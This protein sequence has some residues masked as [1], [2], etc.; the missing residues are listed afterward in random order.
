R[1]IRSACPT[2]WPTGSGRGMTV[3]GGRRAEPGG[4]GP[5]VA[6]DGSARAWGLGYPR[7]TAI[8]G[9]IR[10][11]VRMVLDTDVRAVLPAIR[12]PTLVLHRTEDAYVR[13]DHGR[14][15]ADH[16]PGARYGDLHGADNP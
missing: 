13:A 4:H 3:G 7:A 14:Y 12:V 15:L 10:P 9:T 8:P 6:D 11:M 16:I 5:S 1:T 2:I